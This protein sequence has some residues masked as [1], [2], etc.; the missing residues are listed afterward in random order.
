MADDYYSILGVKRDASQAEIQRAYRDLARKY[1]PDMNPD[2]KSAK[3]KFQ[4]VQK[5]YDVLGNAEKREMYDRYGSSFESM[6]QGGPG[7]GG[8]STQYGPAGGGAGFEE[9]DFSQL[10][11]G[12]GPNQFDGSFGDIF[13][14]FSGGRRRQKS[15]RR[16]ADVEA[17]LT[18][19]FNTSITGGE[20]NLAIQTG[21]GKSKTI[22]VKIPAGIADGKKIRLRGQGNPGRGDGQAGDLLVTIRVTPHPYFTRRGSNLEVNVPVTVAEAALGAKVDVPTPKG[23]ITLTVPPGTSSGRRLRVKGHGVPAGKDANGDLFAVVQ[24]A[25]PS[26]IEDEAKDLLRKF[27]QLLPLDPRADLKW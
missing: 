16:G 6:G 23:T 2:D 3:E 5:A 18:I 19:P 11:G 7:G 9:I 27:D 26:A 25:M 21:D 1:H 17:S 8:W 15:G 22:N 13:R 12:Q 10:F 24:I 4:R 20:G 14:Q